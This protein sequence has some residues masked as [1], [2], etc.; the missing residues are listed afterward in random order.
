MRVRQHH[1]RL[2]QQRQIDQHERMTGHRVARN[3][4][5]NLTVDIRMRGLVQEAS[6]LYVAEDGFAQFQAVDRFVI[7]ED[8]VAE[9]GAN[10]FPGRFAG[11][12]DYGE[13]SEML[14]KPQQ[15]FSNIVI[16]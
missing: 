3:L 11:L 12:D 8:L 2:K 9:L 6:L 14:I 13:Y 16:P 1:A 5:V 15:R 7:V 4:L 10:L